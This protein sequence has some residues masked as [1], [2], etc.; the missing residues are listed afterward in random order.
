MYV[1]SD[2]IGLLGGLN[3][4]SYALNNPLRFVDRLGLHHEGNRCV[5]PAGNSVEC[6]PDVCSHAEPASVSRTL[7]KNSLL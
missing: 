2:P 1:Q 5:D 7:S 6:P 3:T 4:Y